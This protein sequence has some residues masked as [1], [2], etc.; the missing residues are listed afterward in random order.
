MA[1]G[2]PSAVGIAPPSSLT[3]L[4]VSMLCGLLSSTTSKSLCF[5]SGTV[6]SFLS[7]TITSTRTK[8][9]PVLNTGCGVCSAGGRCGSC[10]RLSI[11][12]RAQESGQENAST[13]D[14]AKGGA[15]TSI[16]DYSN[17]CGPRRARRQ[18]SRGAGLLSLPGPV[19]SGRTKSHAESGLIWRRTLSCHQI[20]IHT[21]TTQNTEVTH[22]LRR[23]C[24]TTN[25]C[26]AT[27]VMNLR[28]AKSVRLF[29]R[30]TRTPRFHSLVDKLFR[31]R[32]DGHR[33]PESWRRRR[34][35]L[36]LRAGRGG[37]FASIRRL[38]CSSTCRIRS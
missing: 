21:V 14:G 30:W 32:R 33:D 7:V 23:R 9:M 3:S 22:R 38:A 29:V 19:G 2:G 8:L 10:R 25:G 11:T 1:R 6:L 37:P 16:L 4:K 15:H 34:Q 18:L 26:S 27:A 28:T 5:R 36:S 20:N 12:A 13:D 35:L 17:R 24:R 31:P